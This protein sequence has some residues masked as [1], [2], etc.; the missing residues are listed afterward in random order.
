MCGSPVLLLLYCQSLNSPSALTADSYVWLQKISFLLCLT[1]YVNGLQV[2]A[3]SYLLPTHPI[4]ALSSVGSQSFHNWSALSPL[5]S[6]MGGAYLTC[7]ADCILSVMICSYCCSHG[8]AGSTP[9][10]FMYHYLSIS[11]SHLFFCALTS[12]HTLAS[13]ISST[14]VIGLPTCSFPELLPTSTQIVFSL[15]SEKLVKF[16]ATMHSVIK[17]NHR[18]SVQPHFQYFRQETLLYLSHLI[19][20]SEHLK[21]ILL[22]SLAPLTLTLER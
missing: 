17:K 13:K 19:K 18:S 11:S 8:F 16:L 6:S 7:R 20:L 15:L 9:T 21:P 10:S 22:V 14:F 12:R 1:T 5:K 2:A 4:P 3:A